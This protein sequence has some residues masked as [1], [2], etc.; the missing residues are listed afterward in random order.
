M[1]FNPL[2]NAIKSLDKEEYELI[3][4][5]I[6]FILFFGLVA[7]FILPFLFTI[8]AIFSW[9][10]YAD[11]GP[12]GDLINGV[13]GPFIALMAAILTFLAFYIQ[14]KANT[15]QILNN[16][17]SVAQFK[18]QLD[19]QK[20]QF[21]SQIKI[22]NQQFETQQKLN[23]IERFESRYFELISL[24]KSNVEEIKI[25]PYMLSDRMFAGRNAFVKMYYEFRLIYHLVEEFI[26]DSENKVK[27]IPEEILEVI[28]KKPGTLVP[29][30]L[31]SDKEKLTKI[32]YSLFYLGVGQTSANL[33]LPVLSNLTNQRFSMFL[34]RWLYQFQNGYR[35]KLM[36]KKYSNLYKYVGEYCKVDLA[37]R[38]NLVQYIPLQG[39]VSRLG[40]YYRHLYQTVKFVDSCEESILNEKE[41]YDYVKTI[42]AQLSAHEQA[43][44]YYN[45][46]SA[47]GEN[48]VKEGLVKKYRPIKNIP[49]PLTAF[50][51][52]PEDKF[53][54]EI[55]ELMLQGIAFFEWDEI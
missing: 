16:R 26:N 45:F 52:K 53:K 15:I 42:R 32:A 17:E 9:T 27:E 35:K 33:I 10:T 3:K 54:P 39:H 48:W 43:M 24:H 6:Y 51:F 21:E 28:L 8:P 12:V 1:L 47:G 4:S 19:L 40:H 55:E 7:I 20:S 49:L 30:F 34:V 5:G 2:R 14:Y 18:Q 23:S 46:L 25:V 36:E 37:I 31:P 29:G 41:K 13:A 38:N 22:Q 50:A 11:K 44:L